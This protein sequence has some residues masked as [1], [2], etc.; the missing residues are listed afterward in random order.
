MDGE[1]RRKLQELK[2]TNQKKAIQQ[3]YK[4]MKWKVNF[5]DKHGDETRSLNI[6]AENE[7]AAERLAALEADKRGWSQSF[8]VADAEKV[9]TSDLLTHENN[10]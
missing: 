6:I 2:P 9:D 10:N 8:K 5:F 7:D 1:R 4:T 3:E